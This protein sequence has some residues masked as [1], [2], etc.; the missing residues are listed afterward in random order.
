MTL[1]YEKMM[2]RTCPC[3]TWKP[4]VWFVF[5]LFESKDW[6]QLIYTSLQNHEIKICPKAG[7]IWSLKT[8]VYHAPET[9]ITLCVNYTGIKQTNTTAYH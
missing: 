2:T 1:S 5:L 7:M 8:T 4:F 9:D 6:A 3:E